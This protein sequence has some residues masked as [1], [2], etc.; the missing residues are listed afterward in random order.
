MKKFVFGM[1]AM[2]GLCCALGAGLNQG[3]PEWLQGS[4]D[5][6]RYEGQKVYVPTNQI[7]FVAEKPSGVEVWVNGGPGGARGTTVILTQGEWDKVK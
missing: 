6:N 2:L 5:V 7:V 1:V 4:C 3:K